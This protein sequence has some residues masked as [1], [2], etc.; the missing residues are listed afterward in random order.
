[1]KD[2]HNKPLTDLMKRIREGGKQAR[3]AALTIGLLIEQEKVR[4][5]SSDDGGVGAVLG[6]SWA[7]TRLTAGEVEFAVDQLIAYLNET[8]EPDATA[9]WAVSKS[10]DSRIVPTL[11]ELVDRFA[12]D[13]MREGIAAE[14]LL[15]VINAGIGSK[16]D[17]IAMAA[18]RHACEAGVGSVKETAATFL[19]SRRDPSK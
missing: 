5:K 7:G 4:R 11:A 9:I 3:E 1:M 16:H 19:G 10:Y 15:G 6:A 17:S 14:A 12:S 13:P 2:M 8:P 18:V